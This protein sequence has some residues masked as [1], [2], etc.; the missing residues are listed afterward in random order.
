[1]EQ[2][3]IEHGMGDDGA[4][5]CSDELRGNV[6]HCL[7]CRHGAVDECGERHKW[8]EMGT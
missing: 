1:L 3:Q 4:Q 7:F 5:N 8:I 6:G 2:G